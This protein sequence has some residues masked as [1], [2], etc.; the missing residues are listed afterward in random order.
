MILKPMMKNI[1]K[2]FLS[3]NVDYRGY[4]MDNTHSGG[5][6]LCERY[7]QLQY[8]FDK[9]REDTISETLFLVFH[10]ICTLYIQYF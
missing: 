1:V 6:S 2:N 10:C 4:S 8:F 9:K 5:V 3:I 7:K